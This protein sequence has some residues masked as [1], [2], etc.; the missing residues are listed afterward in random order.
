MPKW[1]LLNKQICPEFFSQGTAV[2]A[3]NAGSLT[4]VALRVIHDGFEQGAFNLANDKIVQVAGPVAVKSRKV[5]IECV[6]SMFAK[7]FLVFS[8]LEV[9]LLVLF[10]GHGG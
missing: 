10:L 2:D 7:R 1:L 5:L 6:F 9:L 4:L 3:E 8:G